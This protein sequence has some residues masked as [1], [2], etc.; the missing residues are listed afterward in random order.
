MI[1][2]LVILPSLITICLMFNWLKKENHSFKANRILIG[3]K[4]EEEC[5]EVF[6]IL[7]VHHCLA[8]SRIIN[9]KILIRKEELY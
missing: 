6:L 3:V 7:F 8:A 2:L 1:L 4:K 9:E 5:L